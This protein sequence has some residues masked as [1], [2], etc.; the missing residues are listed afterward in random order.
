MDGGTLIAEVLRKQGVRFLFTL[1]GGHISPILVGAKRADIRVIDVRHEVN[2]VFAADADDPLATALQVDPL[3]GEA[4][5][6][7]RTDRLGAGAA[8]FYPTATG[9]RG[10]FVFEPLNS[11]TNAIWH[12]YGAGAPVRSATQTPPDRWHISGDHLTPP[13]YDEE[14]VGARSRCVGEYTLR[15]NSLYVGEREIPL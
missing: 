2:A 5:A 10:R 4:P 8:A 1:C 13:G 11:I 7:L 14:C 15:N 6:L 3:Y 9:A 12:D